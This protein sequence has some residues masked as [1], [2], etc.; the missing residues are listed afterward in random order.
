MARDNRAL[1]PLR[2]LNAICFACPFQPD[3]AGMPW[4]YDLTPAVEAL[5][6]WR[7]IV[8]LSK[9]L[10]LLWAPESDRLPT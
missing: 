7:T 8:G 6:I 1:G 2:S 3:V 5:S 10:L 4:V 9:Y